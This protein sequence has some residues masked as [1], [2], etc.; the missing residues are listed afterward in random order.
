MP[1]LLQKPQI[2]PQFSSWEVKASQDRNPLSPCCSQNLCPCPWKPWGSTDDSLF[3]P[4]LLSLSNLA[5]RSV[6]QGRL[7]GSVSWASKFYSGHDLLVCGFEPH[8]DPRISPR[9]QLGAWSL[10]QILCLPLCPSPA[11]PLSLSLS[12][13]LSK[14]N[15][16]LKIVGFFFQ[17]K[18]KT[19]NTGADI[20][21]DLIFLS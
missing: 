12:L 13:S 1:S 11:H 16:H 6:T 8:I 15:K 2:S 21:E 9:W 17:F 18:T 4:P 3:W 10:L 7:G 20:L 5:Q 19:N 14:I